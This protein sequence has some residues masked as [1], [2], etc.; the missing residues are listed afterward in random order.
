MQALNK[1]IFTVSAIKQN[2][3]RHNETMGESF[4]YYSW[5]QD[6]EADFP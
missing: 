4:Q 6:F 3:G 1:L 2:H 5:I